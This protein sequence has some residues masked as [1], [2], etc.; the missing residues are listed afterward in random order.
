MKRLNRLRSVQGKLFM[1]IAAALLLPA[2]LLGYLTYKQT[3]F[4]NYTAV[5]GKKEEL[6]KLSPRF[7]KMFS[8]AE[9]LVLEAA[10]KPEMQLDKYAF[11]EPKR[12]DY[13]NMQKVNDVRQNDFY[14]NFFPTL[15]D[16]SYYLS[17][18]YTTVKGQSYIYPKVPLEVDLTNFDSRERG[19]YKAAIANPDQVNWTDPYMDAV[20]TSIST[21]TLS[22]AVKDASGTIIGVIGL[23]FG[24]NAMSGVMRDNIKIQTIWILG[25]TFV[26]GMTG[27]YLFVRQFAA[28]IK[29]LRSG[30]HKLEAGDFTHKV[31][32]KGQDE[33]ADLARSF[34]DM[35]LSLAG[36]IRQVSVS[37][38]TVT[39]VAGEVFQ[40]TKSFSGSSLEVTRSVEEI[41]TG[42]GEQAAVAE[43]NSQMVN[44]IDSLMLRL[45]E[46][47]GETVA[48]AQDTEELSAAGLRQLNSLQDLAAEGTRKNEHTHAIVHALKTKSEEISH[49]I[50][51]IR[52]I[53][54]QTNLLAL[55][56]S[57]EAARAGE[58]GSGFAVVAHEVK[59]LAQQSEQSADIINSIVMDIQQEI[60]ST[61]SSFSEY[62][63]LMSQQNQSLENTKVAF[64]G[65]SDAVERTTSR[66]QVMSESIEKITAI[67]DGMLNSISN[68]SAISQ[69]TAAGTEEVAATME[70]QRTAVV[71]LTDMSDQLKATA[72][73]LIGETQRFKLEPD[74]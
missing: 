37:A 18:F 8:E 40:Q 16:K 65:I 58:H 13:Q 69:Q 41:A 62:N 5:T 23:D 45:R 42:A 48:I 64:A 44:D 15:L 9:K 46:D 27:L 6:E 70:E 19:W 33:I 20:N 29:A 66:I 73:H 11:P 38:H 7:A 22:K 21:M 57:I 25:I 32:L 67:K 2:S 72:Q 4:V 35:A 26:I 24:L 10:A 71:A 68:L 36:L 14:V 3:E 47:T 61:L 51:I 54:S 63:E 28:R 74:N 31:K 55:N 59:K 50:R 53:A 17:M 52:E 1:I 12:T 60:G 39:E 30:M 34:N 43:Q 49:I 56:A